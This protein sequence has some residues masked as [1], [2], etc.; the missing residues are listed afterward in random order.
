LATDDDD[1]DNNEPA[2]LQWGTT[3]KHIHSLANESMIRLDVLGWRRRRRRRRRCFL[4]Q[5][6]TK[7]WK[8][9]RRGR[10]KLFLQRSSIILPSHPNS[11]YPLPSSHSNSFIHSIIHSKHLVETKLHSFWGQ[12]EEGEH[13]WDGIKWWNAVGEGVNASSS[14]SF[15]W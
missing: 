5:R 8:R 2:A 7:E 13:I 11:H 1:E 12:W 3:T 6:M 4:W 9:R 10:E 15:L 14:S